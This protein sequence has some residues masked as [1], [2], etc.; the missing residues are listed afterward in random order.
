[1]KVY[2]ITGASRGLGQALS[3][4]LNKEENLV[5]SVSRNQ[6]DAAGIFKSC[7]LSKPNQIPGLMDEIFKE[8]EDVSFDSISLVNNAGMLSPICSI[9][10]ASG[11]QIISHITTNF[12]SPAIL[13]SLFI[14]KTQAFEKEKRIVNISTGAAVTA[15]PGWSL[16]CSSKAGLEHFARSVAEEQKMQEF[17]VMLINIAP[18]LVDTAMQDEIRSKESKDFPN[19]ERFREFKENGNLMPPKRVAQWILDGLERADLENGRRYVI[20]EFK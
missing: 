13:T 12:S 14:Q 9:E 4:L 17:P 10:N 15:Y 5:Y 11:E 16:Y 3:E 8:L 1:M 6:G 7:D 18:G 20:D 2:I 19:V